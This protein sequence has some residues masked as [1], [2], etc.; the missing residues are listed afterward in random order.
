[1][2]VEGDWRGYVSSLDRQLPDYAVAGSSESWR[3]FVRLLPGDEYQLRIE[4]LNNPN[5]PAAVARL[6]A[7]PR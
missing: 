2:Q 3:E 7:M 1:L 5:G 4:R 6:R